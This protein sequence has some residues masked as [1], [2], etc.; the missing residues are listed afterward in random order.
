MEQFWRN[1]VTVGGS[2]HTELLPYYDQHW[3]DKTYRF[4][5]VPADRRWFRLRS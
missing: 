4:G 5:N 2:L 1:A 3:G